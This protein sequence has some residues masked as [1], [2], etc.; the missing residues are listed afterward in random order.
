MLTPTC[1]HTPPLHRGGKNIGF[2][3]VSP[4]SK[5]WPFLQASQNTN[6]RREKP[7]SLAWCIIHW[8]GFPYIKIDIADHSLKIQW[9]EPLVRS[10]LSGTGNF[11]GVIHFTPFVPISIFIHTPIW[12]GVSLPYRF[13]NHNHSSILVLPIFYYKFIIK[14]KYIAPL[15]GQ[16]I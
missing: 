4:E 6:R 3:S 13:T 10:S 11:K 16:I 12:Q 8:Y 14:N 15:T 2:K 7:Y 9:P 1:G 5:F